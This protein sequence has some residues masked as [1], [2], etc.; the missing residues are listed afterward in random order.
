MCIQTQSL[1]HHYRRLQTNRFLCID[2]VRYE[3][4]LG[5]PGFVVRAERVGVRLHFSTEGVGNP[6]VSWAARPAPVAALAA[7][8]LSR[9]TFQEA[10]LLLFLLPLGPLPQLPVLRL[11]RV[12]VAWECGILLW[13]GV[14]DISEGVT[15]CLVV[16]AAWHFALGT[17]VRAACASWKRYPCQVRSCW[18]AC[19]SMMWFYFYC[20]YYIIWSLSLL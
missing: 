9:H 15:V 6:Q 5:G 3:N 20:K 4:K 14:T 11:K 8:F 1:K 17:P 10:D 7:F 13:Q 19:D 2:C 16:L 12:A 18:C